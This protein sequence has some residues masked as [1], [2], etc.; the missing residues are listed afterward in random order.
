MHE[1]AG[2]KGMGTAVLLPSCNS[3]HNGTAVCLRR[4]KL[5]LQ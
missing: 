1:K 2:T 3:Y 5:K 4:V